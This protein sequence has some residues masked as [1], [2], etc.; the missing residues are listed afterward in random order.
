M[1]VVT[2]E[3][4]PDSGWLAKYAAAFLNVSLFGDTLQHPLKSFDL[5]LVIT[6]VLIFFSTRTALL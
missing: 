3:G 6:L 2:D 1:A 4:V 5:S